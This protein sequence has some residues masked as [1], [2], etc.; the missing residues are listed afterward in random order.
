MSIREPTHRRVSTFQ[1]SENCRTCRLRQSG[2][3]CQLGPAALRDF[4]AIKSLS[5]YPKNSVLFSE[6][7]KPVGLFVLCYGHVKLSMGSREGKSLM[8]KLGRS[9]DLLGLADVVNGTPYRA[10]AQTI[11]PSQIAFVRREDFLEFVKDHPEVYQNIAK[12]AFS[13]Y[14]N[15]CDQ[16]RSVGLSS[17]QKRLARLLLG[18][19]A[20]ESQ[21]DETPVEI[22]MPLTQ[23]QIGEFV[24]VAR[25][26]VTRTLGDFKD[27]RII[28][29]RG[30]ALT[31]HDRNALKEMIIA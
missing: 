10:T 17:M 26:T 3:F 23:E 28:T 6:D 9:G 11:R 14:G 19:L 13:L 16:L 29:I 22:V 24:G 7:E 18:W 27:R 30:S 4:D 1:R 25:E 15:A 31:I 20:E 12:Q 21:T 2:F 8:L 5:F